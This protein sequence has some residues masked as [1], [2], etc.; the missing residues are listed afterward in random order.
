[1]PIGLEKRVV[2]R[3]ETGV[4]VVR[5]RVPGLRTMP[6]QPHLRKPRPTSKTQRMPMLHLLRRMPCFRQKACISLFEFTL[7]HR[8]SAKKMA[9]HGVG[10]RRTL[11]VNSKWAGFPEWRCEGNAA[12][13]NLKGLRLSK[14][15]GM[16]LSK[17]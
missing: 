12:F 8:S 17:C 13:A 11:R 6:L 10:L 7:T 5:N 16:R 15:R 14:K 2:I 4:V 9:E 3:V 1:M